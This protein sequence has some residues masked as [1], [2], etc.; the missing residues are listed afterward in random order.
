MN[1]T[2]CRCCGGPKQ[3]TSAACCSTC[4]QPPIDWEAWND[5]QRAVD[6]WWERLAELPHYLQ[7]EILS[8]PCSQAALAL[9]RVVAEEMS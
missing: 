1:S 6:L 4:A 3:P 9:N 8:M 2:V 5:A 7:A